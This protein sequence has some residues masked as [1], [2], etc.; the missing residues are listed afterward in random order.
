M[1]KWHSVVTGMQA[2]KVSTLGSRERGHVG[3]ELH[4]Q[5]LNMCWLEQCVAAQQWQKHLHWIA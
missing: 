3:T 1:L 5:Q 4:Y 2:C